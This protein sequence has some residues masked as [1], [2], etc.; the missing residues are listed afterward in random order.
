MFPV[1]DGA[2]WTH[3]PWGGELVDGRIYGRGACDMKC[4]TTASIFTF[5]YLHELRDELHGQLTLVGGLGRGDFR[6]LGAPLSVRAPSGGVRRLLPERRAEQP[7]DMCASAKR[8]RCGS[9]SRC[10][11]RRAWRLY[12]CQQERHRDRREDHRR[13]DNLEDIPAPEASNLAAALDE[14]APAI[15]RAQG[16]GAAR[17]TRRVTVNPGVVQGGLKVN[18]VASDCTFEV[19]IRLP[20]GLDAPPILA[21]VDK[22]SRAYPEASYRQIT[23]QPAELVSARHRDGAAGARQCQGGRRHRSDAG[24]QPRRHRRAAVALQGHPGH[25]LWAVADRHGQHRRACDGRGVLPRRQMPC[26]LRLR[27]Y[28]PARLTSYLHLPLR[29]PRRWSIGSIRHTGA[30]QQSRFSEGGY[31]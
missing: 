22:I 20:N 15:D 16:A 27:L 9:N 13:T 23:L 21:E 30:E 19:D 10:A 3:D 8:A 26:P 31:G 14:A 7:V 17:I 24:D 12:A 11:P 25:C 4:G 2:G 29:A 6:A 18:M 1:G 5:L 28:E